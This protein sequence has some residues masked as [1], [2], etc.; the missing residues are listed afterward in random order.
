MFDQKDITKEEKK[1]IAD[2]FIRYAGIG[3]QSAEGCTKTPST[4]QQHI[5]AKLLYRELLQMGAADVYYDE[6]YCY[7]Y[8]TLPSNLPTPDDSL[9]KDCPDA[10]SKKRENLAPIIGLVAH[11]DTSN[12][13]ASNVVHPHLIENYNGGDI[14]LHEELK[15]KSCPEEMPDLL[16]HKGKML[17]TSDGTSVLGGD[18]KAGVTEIMELF[19][20]FLSHPAYPHGTVRLMFTP[21]EEVGNGTA[22]YD[23]EHFQVDFAYTC[24]GGAVGELE[25]ENFNAASGILKIHGKNTHPGSA[26]GVMKN[27]LL[28]GMEFNSLLPPRETPFY[29][30]GYEGF[31]HLENMEGTPDEAR[32]EYIIRDHD[33]AHFEK[34][35]EMFAEAVKV[36]QDRYGAECFE[37]EIQDSY[38]NM[39]EKIRPHMHLIHNA[40]AAMKAVGVEPLIQPIRGG[41]DGCRLSFE[42]IPCPN[43]GT[44][45]YHWHSRNEYVCVE[46]M[47][48]AVRILA[49]IVEKYAAYTVDTCSIAAQK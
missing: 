17:I 48:L 43:L 41:T 42:G 3:T 39:L 10:A 36:M 34:R 5:L 18:D 9:M 20:F 11:I 16:K 23:R 19:S 6:K 22:C 45:A 24:D 15:I 38:Y 44:G 46:E 2:R 35:K 8:A 27:A 30:E 26:K 12:A 49:R 1:E 29:T 7:V 13:V 32:M 37:A 31:F 28:Y 47:A 4:P 25:Y 21:D 40:T 14:C 33:R